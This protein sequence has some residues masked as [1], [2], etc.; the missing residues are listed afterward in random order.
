MKITVDRDICEAQAVCMKVCPEVFFVGDDDLLQIL[1]ADVAPAQH[2]QVR[3]A[4]LRCPKQALG[5]IE[6]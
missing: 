4:T 2:R 1:V 3:E 5:I 6:D